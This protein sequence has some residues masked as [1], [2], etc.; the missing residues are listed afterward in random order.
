MSF[1]EI[2]NSFWGTSWLVMCVGVMVVVLKGHI[3][4]FPCC[5]FLLCGHSGS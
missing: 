1:A 4:S 3:I 5:V 2:E